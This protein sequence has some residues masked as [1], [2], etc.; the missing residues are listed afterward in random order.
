MPLRIC[1]LQEDMG[2]LEYERRPI[3]NAMLPNWE[4]IES[5]DLYA[6]ERGIIRDRQYN[7]II[8]YNRDNVEIGCSGLIVRKTSI[9]RYLEKI[10]GH[11]II[12]VEYYKSSSLDSSREFEWFIY[13]KDS[14]F[15]SI[16]RFKQTYE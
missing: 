1:Q 2:G 6:A 7:S 16:V 14:G 5:L 15:K 10:D 3:N 13:D 4:F 8:S 9:D 11:L 12:R